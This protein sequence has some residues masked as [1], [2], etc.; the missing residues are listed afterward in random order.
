VHFKKRFLNLRWRLALTIGSCVLVFALLAITLFGFTLFKYIESERI[1]INDTNLFKTSQ[2]IAKLLNIEKNNIKSSKAI[3]Y[4]SIINNNQDNILIDKGF[5][6]ILDSNNSIKYSKNI[7]L[8][9]DKNILDANVFKNTA[10]AK[11][12]SDKVIKIKDAK[13][14]GNSIIMYINYKNVTYQVYILKSNFLKY[15]LFYPYQPIIS[16]IFK[17]VLE[18]SIVFLCFS[19]I[20]FIIFIITNNSISYALRKLNYAIERVSQGYLNLDLLTDSKDEVGKL[21]KN[22]NRMIKSNIDIIAN[23]QKSANSIKGYQNSINMIIEN[24]DEKINIQKAIFIESKE[25]YERLNKSISNLSNKLKESKGI[26]EEAFSNSTK[27]KDM[28]KEIADEINKISEASDQVNFVTELINV[29]SEKTRLIAVN[30][31]IEAS[32]AGEAG[33]GFGVVADEIKKLARLSHNATSEI[34]ELIK[35]NEKRILSGINKIKEI[36]N[37][38]NNV[39]SGIKIMNELIEQFNSEIKNQENI[40]SKISLSNQSILNSFEETIKSISE[41]LKIKNLLNNGVDNIRNSSTVFVLRTDKKETIKD[42]N[43]S[44]KEEKLEYLKEKKNIADELKESEK[45]MKN[46]E[47]KKN[48]S[49]NKLESV[50]DLINYKPKK[51]IFSGIKR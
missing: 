13:R 11:V 48:K 40:C 47:K 42:I 10:L 51:G 31:A 4:N 29:I 27:S 25:D 1:S 26:T 22:F 15:I 23:I 16:L 50:R 3:D 45:L 12:L 49:S 38:L 28:I 18:L 39:N 34:A 37:V 20:C 8:K 5:F 9:I 21:Y 17:T 7:S 33:K 43:Y 2:K 19:I 30:S 41:L 14:A 35:A 46:K 32:R 24:T 36:I 44:T 6:Y